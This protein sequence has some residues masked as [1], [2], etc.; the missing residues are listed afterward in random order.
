MDHDLIGGDSD[1]WDEYG[2][3]EMD[4]FYQMNQNEADDY[5]NE[6]DDYEEDDYESGEDE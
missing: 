2:T 4:D 3:Y 1:L 6:F 5:R